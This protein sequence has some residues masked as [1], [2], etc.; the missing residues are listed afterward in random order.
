MNARTSPFSCTVA[1]LAVA[2]A[3]PLGGTP[4]GQTALPTVGQVLERAGRYVVGYG[5]QLPLLI[6]T[7]TYSQWKEDEEGS[8]RPFHETL[9]AEFALMR[10]ETGDDWVA[11]RDTYEK[12]GKRL[13]EAADRL[14]R[15]F[16][17]GGE[18]VGSA[19]ARR[20]SNES[21]QFNLARMGK[22]FNTP[23]MALFFL[24]PANQA[25]FEFKKNSE[26]KVNGVRVWRIRYK[27][28]TRPTL[29]RSSGG[30]DM[31]VEGSAWIS[32]DDGKVYRTHMEIVLRAERT[33][34][35]NDSLA[36]VTVTYRPGPEDPILV[37]GEMLETYEFLEPRTI[38]GR[39]I[40]TK[41]NCT[42][43][44]TGVKRI[45]R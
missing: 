17:Q 5:E 7:E 8:I 6:A 23:T 2:V 14:Q 41:V 35:R 10:L 45:G 30:K 22:A 40:R 42:A 38:S 32:P 39:D 26:D 44:Y 16:V 36:S 11:Y 28:T 19:L 21:A 3:W 31:P 27:E 12:D 9:V 43:T 13:G 37:P 20:L 24:R 29:Y 33:V 15:L 1:L 4:A 34:N 25:R 18:K